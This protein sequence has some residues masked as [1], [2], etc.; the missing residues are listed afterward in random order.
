M[1]RLKEEGLFS[2]NKSIT[3]ALAGIKYDLTGPGFAQ[4]GAN[5]SRPIMTFNVVTNPGAGETIVVGA[6]T[7]TFRLTAVAATDIKI[8]A[9]VTNGDFE[10]GSLTGWDSSTGWSYDG[11]TTKGALHAAGAMAGLNVGTLSQIWSPKVVVA[12]VYTVVYT[13]SEYSGAGTLIMGI[14]GAAGSTR[15]GN[16]TYTEAITALTDEPLTFTPS[17]NFIGKISAVSVT[18]A[19][20]DYKLETTRNIIDRINLD[21]V[22]VTGTGCT[23]YLL[24]SNLKIALIDELVEAAASAPTFTGDGIKIVQD[25]AWALTLSESVL[26]DTNYFK[27]DPTTAKE[28]I[29]TVLVERNSGTDKNFLY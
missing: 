20:T 12:R 17:W 18:D 8:G 6:K 5:Y 9:L 26:E 3:S 13:I 23:A 16:G 22:T 29:P 28:A 15:S 19:V 10:A 25:L 27:V 4:D 21:K 1:L 7:Y 11:T 14:G 2:A 24:G